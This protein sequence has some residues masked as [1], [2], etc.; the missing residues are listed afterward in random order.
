MVEDT[1]NHHCVPVFSS[2]ECSARKDPETLFGFPLPLVRS[3]LPKLIGKAQKIA[4]DTP[5]GDK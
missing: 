1:I 3:Q 2:L 4:N 5:T